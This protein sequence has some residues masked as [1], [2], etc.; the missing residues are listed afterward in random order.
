MNTLNNIKQKRYV[1]V[2]GAGISM[3]QPSN[4]PNW[5]QYNKT[6]IDVIKEQAC[7]LCPEAFELINAIDV[8]NALPVQC[9]SDLIVSQGAGSSYF[10]LLELLD[11]TSP[12]ANHFALVELAKRGKLK[13]VVTTNFDTLIENAFA[14]QAV[15]LFIIV[16]N[17]EYYELSQT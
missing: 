3:S 11:A 15:S 10:P 4:L 16:R 17:E 7:E 5:W 12:N 1:I 8:E 13:A 6:I 9:I 2:A 14:Q